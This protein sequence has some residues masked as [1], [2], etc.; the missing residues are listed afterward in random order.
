MPPVSDV[1]MSSVSDRT[2]RG[3]LLSR[4]ECLC[5]VCLEIFLEPVTLPCH[6]TFCKPCFLETVDKA[7][8]CCPLCRKRVSTWARQHGRN[9]TL[10]NEQLWGQVQ[11]TFPLQC[12]RRLSGQEGGEEEDDQVL[13]RPLVS[14]PGELR[15]EYEDQISKLAEEKRA[16]EEA[17]RRA[18]EEYIQRLLAEEDERQAEER[19]RLEE[20]QLEDDERMARLLSH[21]L[22]SSPVLESQGNVGSTEATSAKR[23]HKSSSGDIEKFLCPIPP[24]CNGSDSSPAANKENI[25]HSQWRPKSSSRE[26]EECPMPRLDYYGSRPLQAAASSSAPSAINQP[27]T[28]IQVDPC[29]HPNQDEPPSSTKRKSSEVETSQEET[30]VTKRV[31]SSC[32][33]SSSSAVPQEVAGDSGREALTQQQLIQQEKELFDRRQQEE[34]DRRLALLLQKELYKEEVRIATDRR[35][36][37][38]D[39]YLLRQKTSTSSTSTSPPSKPNK[40]RSSPSSSSVKEEDRAEQRVSRN[41]K[42]SRGSKQTT[43]TEMFP[44]L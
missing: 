19:R 12:Q 3:Q 18:S 10:V 37:S 9:H 16:L 29:V 31:C 39:S 22:N 28:S 34:E 30:A 25:L 5:P 11:A 41:K 13:F 14:Q 15:R 20:R 21:E 1:E 6:H 42:T 38:A 2:G 32:P 44:S 24:K 23:K 40:K 35:K 33:S 43:L 27:S 17:E 4:D 26:S 8:M 36:G 7:T